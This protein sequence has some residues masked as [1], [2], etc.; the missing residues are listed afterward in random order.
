M[1][2]GGTILIPWS[3][4]GENMNVTFTIF[5]INFRLHVRVV[6]YVEVIIMIIQKWIGLL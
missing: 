1:G 6:I 4:H 2:Y 5:K 3:P